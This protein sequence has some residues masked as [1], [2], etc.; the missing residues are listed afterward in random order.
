[1]SS[2]LENEDLDNVPLVRMEDVQPSRERVIDCQSFSKDDDELYE[3]CIIDDIECANECIVD[4]DEESNIGSMVS[5]HSEDVYEDD[6]S[7]QELI[8]PEVLEAI[9]TDD[10]DKLMIYEDKEKQGNSCEAYLVDDL[11][12]C[13]EYQGEVLEAAYV[14]VPV[15]QEDV[16]QQIDAHIEATRELRANPRQYAAQKLLN[17]LEQG[18]VGAE[19]PSKKAKTVEETVITSPS[20]SWPTLEIL[21]GGV[22]KTSDKLEGES[23][24]YPDKIQETVSNTGDMM[25]ACAKCSQ[26]FKYLFCLVK[27]VKWHEDQKKIMKDP[28][29]DKLTATERE[30]VNL[31]R[32]RNELDKVYKKQK[33]EMFTRVAV[34]IS[35]LSKAKNIFNK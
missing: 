20:Q 27:H 18:T 24:L 12:T 34:A 35:K 5:L 33:L 23:Y 3:T 29:L 28:E 14:E 9:K 10:A 16:E 4:D 21:P 26:T 13:S 15:D 31:K 8:I 30:L 17:T 32:E 7:S 2:T 19:S 1:M 6:S 22:I 11:E 25:Y